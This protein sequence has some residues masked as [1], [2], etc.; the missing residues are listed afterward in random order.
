[1]SWSNRQRRNAIMLAAKEHD[2]EVI[3][4]AN[5]YPSFEAGRR[6]TPNVL[7]SGATAVIAFDDLTAQGMLAELLEQGISV[8]EQISVVGCDDV[9][10]ATTYPSLTSVSNRT[11]EA[12]KTALTLLIDI[13]E[14]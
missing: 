11:I 13:L 7:A 8:P 9:L 2:I 10:G 5:E 3:V 12:G 14:N 6:T 4:I 1:S